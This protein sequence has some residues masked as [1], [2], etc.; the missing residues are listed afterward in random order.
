LKLYGADD[1]SVATNRFSLGALYY[2]R[3]GEER[4]DFEKA[5]SQLREALRIRRQVS[6]V[7]PSDVA[8][9]L[10]L[11]GSVLVAR[12][13]E[14]AALTL[15]DEAL[16]IRR[17]EL[18]EDHPLTATTKRNLAALLADRDAATAGVLLS[19]ALAVFYR[20]APD[21]WEA[22][23]GEGVLGTILAGAGRYEEAETCLLGSYERLGELRGEE[24]PRT[25]KARE[26]LFELYS[27]WGRPEEAER[28]R[29]ADPHPPDG[30]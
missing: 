28:Y 18:K 7:E 17:R 6:G 23:D 16:L 1:E 5:E 15:Y 12:G 29:A 30:G 19:Q 11:L 8:R 27:A 3:G 24:S 22:A 26:R 25:R 4:G 10:D 9:V 20:D 14:D 2:A 13:E 21:G